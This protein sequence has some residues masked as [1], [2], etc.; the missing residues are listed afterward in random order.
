LAPFSPSCPPDRIDG[1]PWGSAGLCY[2]ANLPEGYRRVVAGTI[3]QMCPTSPPEWGHVDENVLDIGV[4]CQRAR[5]NRGA[6]TVPFDIRVKAR[7]NPQAAP[8]LPPSCE[9]RRALFNS[10]DAAGVCA[11]LP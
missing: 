3:E 7:R 9:E 11:S 6:G 8:P 5:Y 2:M 1:G 4:G 10:L